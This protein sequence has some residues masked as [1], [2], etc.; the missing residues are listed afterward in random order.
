MSLM[1]T[2]SA[3]APAISNAD[4]VSSS[5]FKPY[6]EN[7]KTRGFAVSTILLFSRISLF[8]IHQ[9]LKNERYASV[10]SETVVSMRDFGNSI[11]TDSPPTLPISIKVRP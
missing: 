7:I 4:F 11:D 2:M 5:V 3:V 9:F 6:P 1:C 8:I 10:S